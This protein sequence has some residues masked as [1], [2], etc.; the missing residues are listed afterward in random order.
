MKLLDEK[1]YYDHIFNKSQN[2]SIIPLA[3]QTYAMCECFIENG[4]NIKEVHHSFVNDKLCELYYNKTNDLKSLPVWY[5]RK[6]LP[7][8][9][10][11]KIL[12]AKSTD[13]IANSLSLPRDEIAGILK[14]M[15][16]SSKHTKE[17]VAKLQKKDKAIAIR[18]Q[19]L[20]MQEVEKDLVVFEEAIASLGEIKETIEGITKEQKIQ[21]CYSITNAKHSLKDAYEYIYSNG[22][23]NEHRALLSFCNNQM[24]YTYINGP[25]FTRSV[26]TVNDS[27]LKPFE[28][29]EKFIDRS[30]QTV[31]CFW[32][33][34]N[35]KSTEIDIKTAAE[36]IAEL[37][38]NGIPATNCIANEAFRRY[39]LGELGEFVSEL[40]SGKYLEKNVS[41]ENN[42]K[43]LNFSIKYG[44]IIHNN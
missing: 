41:K 29:R 11:S 30:G 24:K 20:K 37:T 7:G 8:I 35:G 18:N 39:C 4:G 25:K 10:I 3:H 31:K 1:N 22:K 17:L 43:S 40:T 16:K 12:T 34:K 2:L 36:I 44:R 27:W 23:E 19:L 42:S 6:I 21:F 32:P 26:S 9:L 5:R 28:L 38:K 15:S 13:E 14:E 33:D